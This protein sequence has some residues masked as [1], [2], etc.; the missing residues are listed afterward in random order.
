[1][2]T[3]GAKTRRRWGTQI[4]F[5]RYMCGAAGLSCGEFSGTAAEGAVGA[6]G[7]GLWLAS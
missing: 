5:M 3:L 4:I 1:M 6:S 2:P 7:S